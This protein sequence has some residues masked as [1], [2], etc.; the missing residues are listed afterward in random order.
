MVDMLDRKQER[1]RRIRGSNLMRD[2][3]TTLGSHILTSQE[4]IKHFQ[5][6]TRETNFIFRAE[7]AEALGNIRIQKEGQKWG[8]SKEDF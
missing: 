4:S 8:M 3:M 5:A 1:T 2:L 6:L 7:M